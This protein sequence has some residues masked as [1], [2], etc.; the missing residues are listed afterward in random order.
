MK[1]FDHL[2]YL[3][4]N[5]RSAEGVIDCVNRVFLRSMTKPTCGFSYAD[6]SVLHGGRRYEGHEG[7]TLFHLYPKGEREKAEAEEVYSVTRDRG[8]L[9]ENEQSKLLVSLILEELGSDWYDVD[10]PEGEREKKVQYGDIAILVRSKGT[11][12]RN[13]VA[14]LSARDIPVTAAADVNVCDFWEGKL[15]VDWLSYLDNAKQ[16]IPFAGA[17]LSSLGG[18]TE[19]D[20]AQIRLRFPS[21]W[22]FREACE[23]YVEKMDDEI[24]KRLKKFY[25]LSTTLRKQCAVRTAEEQKRTAL[26]GCSVFTV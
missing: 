18:F 16:D 15:L 3:T 19:E 9:K 20:L 10:A 2:I 6:G 4:E 17:L 25:T 5:F 22:Y 23:N 24:S 12:A 21:A 13:I 7:K 1:S 8:S 26:V 11:D 14:A